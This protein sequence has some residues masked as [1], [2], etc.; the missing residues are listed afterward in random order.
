MPRKAGTRCP[1][2]QFVERT[3]VDSRSLLLEP[4]RSSL[5]TR[6]VRRQRPALAHLPLSAQQARLTVC[7]TL[8]RRW[9]RGRSN[10]I[11]GVH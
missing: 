2:P 8:P 3:L 4:L 7:P 5:R 6:A 11:A 1:F 9:H 10:G